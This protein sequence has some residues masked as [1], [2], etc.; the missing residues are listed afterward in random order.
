MK[1]LFALLLAAPLFLNTSCG[2][3]KKKDPKPKKENLVEIK[4]GVYTEYYPGRTAV[5]FQGP[6]DKKGQRDGRWFFYTEKGTEQSTT[7]YV[8]GKKNGLIMVRYPSGNVR[9]SGF[10][11]DDKEVGAWRFYKE[12]GSLDFEKDYGNFEGEPT[13]A[14]P[15][16]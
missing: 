8:N 5:K 1:F 15:Q 12:D 6:Q 16:N 14:A 2:D 7:E 3:E 11:Q 13:Q 9:Y 10:Y 4:D